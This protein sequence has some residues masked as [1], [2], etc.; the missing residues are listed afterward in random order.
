MRFVAERILPAYVAALDAALTEAAARLPGGPWRRAL[1]RLRARAGRTDARR[2]LA[3]LQRL[4]M[5]GEA[6]GW[7]SADEAIILRKLAYR[8]AALA[9]RAG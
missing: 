7:L 6:Q 8:V 9:D 2:R 1:L 5:V 3:A 4:A